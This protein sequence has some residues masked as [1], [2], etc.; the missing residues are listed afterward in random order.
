[1]ESIARSGTRPAPT[2]KFKD[3]AA[4][5][6]E[7]RKL[8][9]DIR[10]FANATQ[11]DLRGRPLKGGIMQLYQWVLMISTH[12]QRHILQIREIKASDKYP[13]DAKK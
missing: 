6:A 8:R 2:G 12:A 9:A 3:A 7:F 10:A 5:L 11:D 1:M 4:A 13:K